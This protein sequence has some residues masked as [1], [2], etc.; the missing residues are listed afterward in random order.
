MKQHAV[1]HLTTGWASST[2]DLSALS[3]LVSLP[4]LAYQ[5]IGQQQQLVQIIRIL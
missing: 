4:E 2:D 3:R 5:D 1:N